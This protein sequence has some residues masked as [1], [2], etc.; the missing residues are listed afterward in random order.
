MLYNNV[1]LNYNKTQLVISAV[2]RGGAGGP[3]PPNNYGG[4]K[5]INRLEV[6]TDQCSAFDLDFFT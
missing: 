4:K 3:G 6:I 5:S 2:A 1:M